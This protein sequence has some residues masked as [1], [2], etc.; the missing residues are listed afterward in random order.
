[1]L[2]VDQPSLG[3]DWRSLRQP[4]FGF[5]VLLFDV[6]GRRLQPHIRGT[7]EARSSPLTLG[8]SRPL[9][10]ALADLRNHRS[11]RANP[12]TSIPSLSGGMMCSRWRYTPRE[13]SRTHGSLRFSWTWFATN[14]AHEHSRKPCLGY[15]RERPLPMGRSTQSSG[16]TAPRSTSL[17][18][19]ARSLYRPR[20]NG[21]PTHSVMLFR[22]HPRAHSTAGN[23]G[24]CSMT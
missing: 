18:A 6:F 3:S 17:R 8:R 2:S 7:G 5:A 20:T 16:S 4:G 9:R 19:I 10:H 12:S 23:S 14:S 13:P 1:M 15:R 22:A 21:S 24:P 11:S